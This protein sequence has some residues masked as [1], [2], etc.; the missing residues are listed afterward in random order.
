MMHILFLLIPTLSAD[1]DDYKNSLEVVKG[2]TPEWILFE[3]QTFAMGLADI[4]PGPY[5]NHWKENAKPQHSVQLS[6]FYLHKTEVTVMAYASYLSTLQ[7][8]GASGPNTSTLMP[9]TQDLDGHFLPNE[10]HAQ[11][12]INYVS[13]YDAASFCAA[14]G[15]RLPT[16]AEWELAAK[17]NSAEEPR[18]FPWSPSPTNCN[19]AVYFTHRTL[20]ETAPADVGSRSPQGDTPDGV[21]DLGGNVSEWTL[22]WYGRYSSEATI[23]PS[24]PDTGVYK[25]LRGGGFRETADA[26]RSTDRVMARPSSRSEG[27][28]FRCAKDGN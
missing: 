11:R 2:T 16:E 4:E 6:S 15:A 9:I 10:G 23:D 25:V 22:D 19:V 26:M 14:I 21:S 5:G 8:Y 3:E 17:G 28:G 7:R 13:W 24:G 27:I 1:D 18:A 12:A 20:C